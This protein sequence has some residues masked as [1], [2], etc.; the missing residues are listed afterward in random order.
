MRRSVVRMS[1]RDA[2]VETVS[3]LVESVTSRAAG[4]WD[5][6]SVAVALVA[7]GREPRTVVV[8]AGPARRL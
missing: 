7:T 8:V 5:E 2:V 1:S 6:L 3:L 4:P